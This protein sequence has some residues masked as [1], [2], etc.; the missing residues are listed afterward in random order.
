MFD[1]ENYYSLTDIQKQFRISRSKVAKIL[2]EHQ[3]PVIEN[4]ITYGTY[5]SLTA[6]YYLKK[7]IDKIISSQVS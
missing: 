3:P 6:K 1:R 5:Y 7:D 4:K 2:D